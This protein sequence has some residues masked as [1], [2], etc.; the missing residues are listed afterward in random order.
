MNKKAFFMRYGTECR[1]F[2]NG[3]VR[4]DLFGSFVHHRPTRSKYFKEYCEYFGLT[5]V[6]VDDALPE[7]HNIWGLR[8]KASRVSR[9]KLLKRQGINWRGLLDTR[10]EISDLLRGNAA[11]FSFIQLMYV[12]S[13]RGYVIPSLVQALRRKNIELVCFAG[14]GTAPHIAFAMNAKTAGC[15]TRL[16]INTWKQLYVNSYIPPVFDEIVVW[17]Q[18]MKD[19]YVITNPHL[20]PSQF[21]VRGNPRFLAL[22][23]HSFTTTK[24]QCMDKYGIRT[25]RF[26]LYTAINPSSYDKEPELVKLVVIKLVSELGLEA[27]TLLVKTN[28]MDS[29]PSRW[30]LLEGHPNVRILYSDWEYFEDEDFNIPSRVSEMEWF[31]LLMHCDI[32]MNIASTVTLEALICGKATINIGFDHNGVESYKIM[33]HAVSPYYKSLLDR[34]DVVLVSDIE[35]LVR[36]YRSLQLVRAGNDIGRLL[37]LGGSGVGAHNVSP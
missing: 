21:F 20:N 37:W 19:E 29:K 33:Q 13:L 5:S 34:D 27:P 16:Y 18:D 36:A 31:D 6:C 7:V 35:N 24:R 30:E 11:T 23:S 12:S 22:A 8:L 28:P 3:L 32:T 25:E 10:I 1:I 9:D 4:K 14:H 15:K 2:F 26:I 17:G